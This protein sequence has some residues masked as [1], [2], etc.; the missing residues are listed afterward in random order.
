MLYNNKILFWLSAIMLIAGFQNVVLCQVVAKLVNQ[1][2]TKVCGTEKNKEFLITFGLG[3]VSKTDSLFAFDLIVE[4]DPTK[5]EI[6]GAIYQNTLSEFLKYRDV[7][8][9]YEFNQIRMFG[10]SDQPLSGNKELI[11]FWGRL[12][13]DCNEPIIM[14]IFDLDLTTDYKPEYVVDSSLIIVPVRVIDTNAF[15]ELNLDSDS[16]LFVNE[17]VSN[18]KLSIEI[19]PYDV[20]EDMFF[21][22]YQNDNVSFNLTSVTSLNEL[23]TIESF[24]KIDSIQYELHLRLWGDVNRKEIINLAIE[25]LEKSSID[26][27]SQLRVVPRDIGNCNCFS[28]FTGDSIRLISKA[29]EIDTTVSVHSKLTPKINLVTKL[30]IIEIVNESDELIR[31][32]EIYDVLGRIVYSNKVDIDNIKYII[33]TQFYRNGYYNVRIITNTKEVNKSILIYN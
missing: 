22:I 18:T 1:Y 16:L 33:E 17:S 2:N 5:I 9:G 7:N 30:N 6:E 8:T 14:K 31:N 25:E 26:V 24:E 3:Q 15:V 19:N 32:V 21:Y 11:G 23:V 27:E 4:Y 13:D 20:I 29:K 12:L 28:K 10:F